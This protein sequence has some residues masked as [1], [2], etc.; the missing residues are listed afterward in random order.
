MKTF[1]FSGF[2]RLL[3]AL[4]II[5]A[6]FVPFSTVFAGGNGSYSVTQTYHNATDSFVDVVPCVG[7][8][9]TITLTYNGVFHFNVNKAGDFWGTGT[10]TGSVVAVPLDTSLPTYTGHFTTWFGISENNRNSVQT[11]T[12]SV[13]AYGSDGSVIKFNET[14]HITLNANGDVVVAFDKPVCH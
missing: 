9:A 5:G 13:I 8:P 7:D 10:Q 2:G 11:D 14:Q 1:H 6:L 12:F 4:L 3:A